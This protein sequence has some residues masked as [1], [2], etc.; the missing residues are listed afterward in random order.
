[1]KV[2]YH[3]ARMIMIRMK[4]KQKD[5]VIV[6]VYMPTSQHTDEEVE[7][8]YERI[9]QVI[10]RERKGAYIIVM[11][12]WNAVA[13]EGRDGKTVGDFGLG[14]RNDRGQRLV[15]FCKENYMVVGNTLFKNNKRRRYTWTSNINGERFQIDYILVQQ[16]YRNA[17]KSAKSYPG[18][19]IWSDHNLVIA[20]ICVKL[21][22]VWKGNKKEVINLAKLKE[23][24]RRWKIYL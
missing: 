8:C 7:D 3:D 24:L 20:E 9:E 5:L 12:D 22:R 18:A 19:D 4:G 14:R 17:L 1:M 21:K 16:R 2:E 10:E 6:Q 15:N 11:G 13:G 23:N